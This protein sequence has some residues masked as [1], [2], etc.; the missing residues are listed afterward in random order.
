[1]LKQDLNYIFSGFY[2]DFDIA[3]NKDFNSAF[4]MD[5]VLPLMLCLMRFFNERSNMILNVGFYT[6]VDVVPNCSNVPSFSQI[7]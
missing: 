4:D 7:L 1:M 3:L 5:L 6:I 2:I